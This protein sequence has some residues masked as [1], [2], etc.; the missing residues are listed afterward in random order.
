MSAQL[1]E[2]V[3]NYR[4][5][6]R[7]RRGGGLLVIRHACGKPPAGRRDPVRHAYRQRCRRAL[8]DGLEAEEAGRR[9]ARTNMARESCGESSTR[10]SNTAGE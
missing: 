5:L 1:R 8:C 2:M 3:R 6:L 7:M 10:R 9:S 4:G